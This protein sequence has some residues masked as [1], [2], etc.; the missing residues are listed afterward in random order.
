MKEWCRL[1]YTPDDHYR[2]RGIGNM[3]GNIDVSFAD[4]FCSSKPCHPIVSSMGSLDI[5]L[6]YR[7]C[8]I[9]VTVVIHLGLKNFMCQSTITTP[10]CWLS[11]HLPSTHQLTPNNQWVT[12]LPV[13]HWLFSLRR[14]TQQWSYGYVFAG[15]TSIHQS[16]PCKKSWPVLHDVYLSPALLG[17][18]YLHPVL[19]WVIQQ[20]HHSPVLLLGGQTV[21]GYATASKSNTELLRADCHCSAHNHS[22]E[23]MINCYDH[24]KARR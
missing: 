9:Q 22:K 7:L 6:S 3:D 17:V 14:L 16:I 5:E 8:R 20:V 4:S 15:S 1:R 10:V 21:K 23:T 12:H 13:G 24:L 11:C 18:V 2:K 19:L